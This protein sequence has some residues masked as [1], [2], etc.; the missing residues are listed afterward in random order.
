MS[1]INGKSP[2]QNPA[3]EKDTSNA[4]PATVYN[5]GSVTTFTAKSEFKSAQQLQKQQRLKYLL[6]QATVYSKFLSSKFIK[7]Q[8]QQ[9]S[10]NDNTAT[11]EGTESCVQRSKTLVSQPALLTGGT[12]KP[13]QLEG[14]E[15]LVSLYENGLNGI[16]ADEMGL[17]KTLQC[18]AFLAFL[19]EKG[20]H[21]PF[22][23]AAPLSTLANWTAELGRFAP[24]IPYLLY[25]G[26]KAERAELR[27][28]HFST[29]GGGMEPTFPVIITSYEIIMNDKAYLEAFRWKFIIVDEGHRIKNLN[30]KLIKTLKGFDSANRLL[31]TGTPLQNNLAELWSLLNFLLPDIFDDLEVFQ[32]W[33]DV[34]ELIDEGHD[35]GNDVAS[36]T[37]QDEQH[38]LSIVANLHNILRPFLLRRLKVDVEVDLPPKREYIISCEMSPLQRQY[39]HAALSR[40]LPSFIQAQI[41][42]VEGRQ[43]KKTKLAATKSKSNTISN[44]KSRFSNHS[45]RRKASN[46]KTFRSDIDNDDELEDDEFLAHLA[47]EADYSFDP[48]GE[49]GASAATSTTSNTPTEMKSLKLQNLFMQLR[50]VCNHPYLFFHPYDP[51]TD[52][53]MIDDGLIQTSGKL[54]VLDQLL[55]GLIKRQHRTLIFSQMTGMLDL[56]EDFLALRGIQFCRIDGSTSQPQ[57]EEELSR[58]REAG[59]DVPVFLLSTRAAGLGINLVAADTVIFYDSDWNPQMDLQAQDRVHRIGQVKPVLI[60][61]LVSAGSV[62]A[63]ILERASTKRK[64][65]RVV[66]HKTKFKGIKQLA[67]SANESSIQAEELRRILQEEEERASSILS[68]SSSET[69]AGKLKGL[70]G[71]LL[72]QLLNRSPSVFVSDAG[73]EAAFN[74][75]ESIV[76]VAKPIAGDLNDTLA[77]M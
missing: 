54:V 11:T 40:T 1:N 8:Q 43:Q 72:E 29:K 14:L 75:D 47:Q 9:V 55:T 7:S 74:G 33:F 67:R 23:I 16:L 36:L 26:A 57:R 15:W 31:L 66:I 24:S 76:R 71:A 59:M 19:R 13:Y 49:E 32:R 10:G 41:D 34:S 2:I 77:G 56:L 12:L 4:Q 30:C 73:Q 62:E 6:E 18:I 64:L 17:G 46:S 20:V 37:Q 3:T 63:K 39:Y 42:A 38:R 5:S 60:Y 48:E 58:F 69:R 35:G 50:K 53:L 25:H 27:K 70:S 21:G 45:G 22:L 68:A 44:G 52:L 28:K 51:K 61:R 65:E